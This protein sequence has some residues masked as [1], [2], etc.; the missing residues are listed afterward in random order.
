MMEKHVT[1]I[2]A[3]LAGSEAAWQA[4]NAGVKVTLYEMRPKKSSPA[5]HTE[6]FAELVCSNS[7]RAKG[8]GNAVGVLKEE[9]RQFNSLIM[10]A[11]AKHEVPA[12]GALAVDR[13]LFSA[14]VTKQLKN[15]PNI[16]VVNEEITEI[17]AD[18]ITVIA[19]GPL[20]SE[21]LAKSI[22]EMTDSEGLYFYDA[23][24]PIIEKSSI[25]MDKV[26]LKSRYDKGEAAYL[27]CPMSKE[28]FY[29]F[30]EA[31]VE[32]EVAP[33]NSFEK[34]TYFEGCMPIEVMANRGEKT[35]L[36]GPMK[37]VGL[38][39]PKTGKR[40]YAVVQLRQDNAAGSL[41][42]IV[43]FQTHLKWG[44]QKRIIQMIP[45][46][47]NAEIVRY[48]VMHRNTFMNSPE[49]LLPTY[50]AQGDERL[51][52]AGQMTGVEGYVESAASGLL[53]GLN[54]ARLAQEK[55]PLIF[56]RETAMG[57]LAYYITHT[58][59]KHFQPMNVNF[60]IIADLPERIRDKK[61]RNEQLAQRALAHVE[62]IKQELD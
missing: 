23:A 9:M 56:P 15:H 33:L 53:A 16:T 50:Q 41:Y 22:V 30:R 12:G 57:A 3:G 19:T 17:P 40:P 26:Y 36:F 49:L 34:E 18:G 51:F 52:F 14:E 42:N 38:E 58:D 39:D 35:M 27:N 25:D 62:T 43:G 48:G 11:A 2:G 59:A 44:E 37:P 8:L 32:A 4:A 21:S 61:E 1:I 6:Q 13:H 29:A 45:G 20:T 31:L 10:S 28:E 47:E 5:H 55:A 46:L 54:A 24:A 7:F 60:G